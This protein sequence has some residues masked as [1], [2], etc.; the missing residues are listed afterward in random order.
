MG[1]FAVVLP[2]TPLGVGEAFPVSRWPLHVT[3]VEPFETGHDA[4]WVA[5]VVGGQLRGREPVEV[6]ASGRAMFGR[7]HDVPVTLLRDRGPLGAMRTRLLHALRMADVDVARA[8]PDFRPH[9]TDGVHGAVRPG[10]GIRLTQVALVDLRPPEGPSMRS[11]AAAWS[12]PDP[13]APV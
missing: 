6:V 11:V 7:R 13:A 2:L 8:R 4:A 1:R 12:L 9:V 5:D 10:R 3:V